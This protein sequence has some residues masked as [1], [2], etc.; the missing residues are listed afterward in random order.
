[1][2]ARNAGSQPI[3]LSMPLRLRLPF[4]LALSLG[5]I[6]LVLGL[7]SAI[8]LIG[9][10]LILIGICHLPISFLARVLTLLVVGA[11]LIALRVGVL[12]VP[13]SSAIW[14]LLGSMFMFRLIIYMYDQRHGEVQPTFSSTLAYFFMLPNVSFPF[15]P[16]IDYRTFRRTYYDG[17]PYKIYQTGI[18]WMFRGAIHLILYRL[19][20]Y[21]LALAPQDV[22][23]S[24]ELVRFL[25]TNYLLYLRVSGL[26][27]LVVGMMHLFGFNL[28]ETHHLYYLAS[29]FTDYWRRINI[30]W[31]DFMMKVF[32]YPIFFR[33]RRLGSTTALVIATLLVF[34]ATMLLHSYQWFWIRGTYPLTAQ[35]ALFWSILAVLVV[36]NAVWES[37]KGRK[38]S[39]GGAGWSWGDLPARVARTVGTFVVI[40]VLWALWTSSSVSEW[41]AL[42]SAW[43]N[44]GLA[45]DKSLMPTLLVF[46]ATVGTTTAIR[47]RKPKKAEK[48]AQRKRFS[49]LRKSALTT[50]LLM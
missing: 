14:P 15:F 29:S 28:P 17:E 22:Q 34:V 38:R 27:H 50:T 4:F 33:L 45:L 13:W 7:T 42:L 30:Y 46:A 1:M 43:D 8:W 21:H 10:G 39:L 35:D 23:S 41:A 40:C 2:S 12:P 18:A 19:V 9:L 26:F 47:P 16:V 3:Q 25:I 37:K 48:P 20:Y 49:I 32:Y 11:S 5:G 24:S 44:G 36:V 6:G 31:K